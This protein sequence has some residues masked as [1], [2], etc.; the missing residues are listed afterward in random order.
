[1]ATNNFQEDTK[2]A[3]SFTF[4]VFTTR[5]VHFRAPLRSG[6]INPLRF[7]I[8]DLPRQ[9]DTIRFTPQVVDRI[10]A[11]ISHERANPKTLD[12][13]ASADG[14]GNKEEDTSSYKVYA[15]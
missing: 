1:M 9:T 4:Q 2:Y 5:K 6:K 12:L 11:M 8:P 15:P 3:A 13:R 10:N 7:G 14:G